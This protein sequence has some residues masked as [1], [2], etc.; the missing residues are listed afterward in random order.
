MPPDD[1]SA[2]FDIVEAAERALFA[3]RGLNEEEYTA[4]WVA[5]SVVERQLITCGEAVKR[6]TMA[7]RDAH[8][9][10]P[11]RA[12]AGLRDVLVHG[13]DVVDSGQIWQAVTVALPDLLE[14]VQAL[15]ASEE[16]P[17]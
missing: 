1:P 8:P 14:Q 11:W 10:V 9:A 16:G 5:R 7:F 4:D 3:I 2:L 6:L 17:S 13:Y 12:V 15:L